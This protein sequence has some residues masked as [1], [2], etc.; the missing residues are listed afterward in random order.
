MLRSVAGF[1]LA[2]VLSFALAHGALAQGAGP[3]EV[4]RWSVAAAAA[5]QLLDSDNGSEGRLEELRAEIVA[6]RSDFREATTQN[7][8]RIATLREQLTALG[9]KPEGEGAKPES[10]DVAASRAELEEQL[11][12]L[13]T[14]VQRAEAEY[15][16]ADAIISQ[17][18]K[19]L[20]ERQA[21]ELLETSPSPLNPVYW[22]PAFADLN[23]A[24]SKLWNEKAEGLEGDDD[25]VAGLPITILLG[26]L[27]T[28]LILRGRRWSE[29][30]VSSLQRLGARGFGI[31]RFL[32]SLLRIILP[33]AGLILLALAVSSTGIFG[34][35]LNEM[36][37]LFAVLGGVMLGLRWVSERVFS[38]DDDEALI[39]LDWQDRKAARFHVSC[40]TALIV[41]AALID[42]VLEAG[43][44]APASQPVLMF[45]I[46]LLA[47]VSL[48]CIG[49]ILGRVKDP[50][51]DDA[52]A[53]ELRSSTLVG[54]IRTLGKGAILVA[55]A[56]PALAAFGYFHAAEAILPPY[57]MTLTLLGLVMTLQRFGA[58]VYG[59][60]TG[61]GAQA[62][63]AL[64]PVL[65]GFVLLVLSL[66]LLALVWGVRFNDLTELW[67]V[68]LRGF[69]IG[70]SR[71]SP[72]DFI[73][74]AVIFG[75][76][77][78]LTRLVQSAL[79]NNVLPKT[80]I[81]V[82]GQNAIVSGLGYVGI[83]LAALAA[84]T[85]AGIDL[86][87]LA[88]VAGA[89][90]VGI[91]FGLQNIVSNFVS[92]IILLIERP[93]SEG[94]W[95]EAGG[96]MGYVRD[97]SVRST[98]IET[99][100]K[101]DVIVPNADLISGTVTNYTRGN[102]V[103]RV[104]IP[105]GVAYGSDA[106]QV[107]DILREIAEAH[108]MVLLAPPPSVLLLNF[109]AD[110]LEFEVRCVLRDV[111]FMLA[112]KN[113]INHEIVARFKDAQIEIPFAQRDVWLRNP[114]VLQ[115]DTGP[116]KAA[117]PETK[118]AQT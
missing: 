72:T 2:I 85:G 44:P 92:G 50:E 28:V 95:I 75:V 8:A 107:E 67:A 40:S 79:R 110:A 65:F 33:F 36:F 113:D 87:S 6:F 53:T 10:A 111:N 74:F 56:T 115:G 63:E 88:I 14:P 22:R 52:V 82:G 84:I 48:Y 13:L 9:P 3:S 58:D 103:G 18:D 11:D 97:I 26:A 32:V 66:P 96:H 69:S 89:L 90:S 55:F 37:L 71:I 118:E 64:W 31:W 15:V 34:P 46:T 27:G 57:F 76:G 29:M 47:A 54:T 91:G 77:Y 99:F 81:D 21:E 35:Q 98:R 1:W 17:I 20:R 41:V 68:F 105:V 70:E 93:I 73:A 117:D 109:G 80:R 61:Q 60:I 94:D 100:D 24:L 116:A 7:A 42:E 114:E 86:S 30:I 62:R 39:P 78:V 4:T 49:K 5:E 101:T 19:S 12:T 59:A 51:A 43:D 45:L 16:R 106:R 38:R 23:A 112:V 108:P 104:I 83:F 102:T 25:L